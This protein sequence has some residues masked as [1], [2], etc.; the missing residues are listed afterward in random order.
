MRLLLIIPLAVWLPVMP[1][2]AQTAHFGSAA[3]AN[4]GPPEAALVP[5]LAALQDQLEE[6]GWMIR[7][8]GTFVLQ[9]N[10]AFRSPYRGDNSLAPSANARA[11]GA[12]PR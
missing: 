6:Q 9:G 3:S 10:T 8:Q 12:A 1:A 4:L 5:S 7:G 11:I 2:A